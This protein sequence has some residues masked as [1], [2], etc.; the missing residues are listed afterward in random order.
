MPL[1]SCSKELVRT[2]DFCLLSGL[3]W[4]EYIVWWLVELTSM[5]GLIWL[6]FF[7][8]GDVHAF[9]EDDC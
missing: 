3:S 6:D 8:P 7:S 9:C 5:K 1:W 2:S 4:S